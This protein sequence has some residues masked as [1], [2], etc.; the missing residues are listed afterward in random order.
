MGKTDENKIYD[1]WG[2]EDIY[3]WIEKLYKLSKRNFGKF[4]AVITAFLTISLWVVRSL[5]YCFVLGRFSVYGIDSCYI[6][7]MS[8]RFLFELVKSTAICIIIL[9]ANWLYYRLSVKEDSSFLKWKRRMAKLCFVLMESG[10]L[11]VCVIVIERIP[12]LELLKEI[13]NSSIEQI[14]P[15]IIVQ[16]T[17]LFTVNIYGIVASIVYKCSLIGMKMKKV[18]V[19]EVEKKN[20]EERKKESKKVKEKR[21]YKNW[22][23]SLFVMLLGFSIEVI[24]MYR[25]GVYEEERRVEYKVIEEAYQGEETQ[26]V[27]EE[28]GNSVLYYP[29]VFE[30][31]EVYILSRLYKENN[32]VKIDYDFQVIR[33]KNNVESK[34]CMDIYDIEE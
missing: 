1:F 33:D 34:K 22:C 24:A 23:W 25:L 21:K 27:F 26:Y 15:V 29:I 8:E 16:I 20:N 14:M 17:L 30:N 7:V 12:P 19:D 10:I 6:D 13:F 2:V 31:S 5:G 18:P 32:E 3:K 28:N 4:S 11:S 9:S